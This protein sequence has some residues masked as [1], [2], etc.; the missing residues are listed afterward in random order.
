MDP[1]TEAPSRR[2]RFWGGI[3]IIAHA[4]GVWPL[5]VGIIARGEQDLNW[6]GIRGPR[7]GL[8]RADDPQLF[9][10]ITYGFIVLG[11]FLFIGGLLLADRNTPRSRPP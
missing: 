7:E 6:G 8:A 5:L 10:R 1:T 3:G 11:L 4:L 9:D 2:Q